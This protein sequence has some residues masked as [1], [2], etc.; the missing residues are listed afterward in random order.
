MLSN[1]EKNI[2]IDFLTE[3]LTP[4]LIYIF[5][6]YAKNSERDNSDIDI[7]ILSEREI[8]E[9]KLFLLAQ[10]LADKLKKEVDLV[11][12]KKAST[13]FKAQIIQGKLIFNKDN[14]KKMNFELKTFREY[15]KL[16]EER[17]EI[18]AKRWGVD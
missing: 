1:E 6:S 18:L 14:Y 12:I 10:K 2:I 8:D 9:Y 4:E 17:K 3:K 15:A 16:N 11:D 5:G 7:A 13:V